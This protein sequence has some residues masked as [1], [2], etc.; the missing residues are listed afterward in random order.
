VVVLLQPRRQE[1]VQLLQRQERAGVGGG[2]DRYQS[3]GGR[4]GG[5]PSMDVGEWQVE[6]GGVR[7]GGL[8][9]NRE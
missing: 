1:P 3:D 7:V 6:C 2:E 4:R 9:W 8:R 5:L